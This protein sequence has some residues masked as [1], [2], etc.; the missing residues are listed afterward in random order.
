[1]IRSG[2][3]EEDD[4][5]IAVE[6]IREAIELAKQRDTKFVVVAD[7]RGVE[8]TTPMFR[9]PIGQFA[10]EVDEGGI[11]QRKPRRHHDPRLL[12][13]RLGCRRNGETLQ[14]R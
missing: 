9:A 13:G 1:M 10:R 8:R 11:W 2:V 14:L 6:A 5:K 3:L 7:A 4:A 12:G